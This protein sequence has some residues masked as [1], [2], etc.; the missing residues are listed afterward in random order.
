MKIIIHEENKIQFLEHGIF[1]LSELS[2]VPLER[3]IDFHIHETNFLTMAGIWLFN[4]W[5]NNIAFFTYDDKKLKLVEVKFKTN[6]SFSPIKENDLYELL[7]NKHVATIG[8]VLFKLRK[9]HFPLLMERR[10]FKLVEKAI[11]SIREVIE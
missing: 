8:K 1:K 2:K 6:F 11:E 3:S 9:D 5:N 7:F 4:F 10:C